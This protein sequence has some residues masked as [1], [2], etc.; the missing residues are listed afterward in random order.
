MILARTRCLANLVQYT[1]ARGVHRAEVPLDVSAEYVVSAGNALSGI[2]ARP[3]NAALGDPDQYDH[4][5]AQVLRRAERVAGSDIAVLLESEPG[6]EAETFARFIHERSR[7]AGGRFVSFPCRATPEGRLEADLFGQSARPFGAPFEG[8]PGLFEVARG[9][10]LFLDEITAI[11]LE[12]Q[13]RLSRILS[14][15]EVMRI[16]GHSATAVDVRIVAGTRRDLAREVA[17]GRFLEDLYKQLFIAAIRLPSIRDR[18][19]ELPALL[20]RLLVETNARCSAMTPKRLSPEARNALLARSWPGNV[21]ELRNALTRLVV[22]AERETISAS[23]VRQHLQTEDEAHR[24]EGVL[25]RALDDSFRMEELLD[26]VSRS[27]IERALDESGGVKAKAVELLGMSN[28]TTLTNW[29]KRLGIDGGAK[30]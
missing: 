16:N 5:M 6:V 21:T 2:A 8:Q 17:E 29:M 7:R 26:E 10:T 25:G 4:V 13:I 20:D 27:Y 9:A 11:S 22:W 1:K 18:K 28:A 30:R 15:G 14:T 19:A 12:G 3:G 24:E 23:D